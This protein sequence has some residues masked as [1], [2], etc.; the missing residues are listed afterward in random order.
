MTRVSV[1][2]GDITCLHEQ[3]LRPDAVVNAANEHLAAG[4]GVC[5]AI[6]AAAGHQE[7]TEACRSLGGCPTGSAVATPAFG[8]AAH[9]VHHIV[10]AVG[11]VWRAG[12]EAESDALLADT[13][14]AALAVA[15][16]AGAHRVAVPAISTGIY[17][18]PE[19][20][21]ASITARTVLEDDGPLDDVWLVAFD[22]HAATVLGDALAAERARHGPGPCQSCGAPQAR[23]WSSPDGPARLCPPCATLQGLGCP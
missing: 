2:V 9:G 15:G 20:R 16:Q 14:R 3:G 23:W 8:L 7:L 12:H 21:A 6:F 4:S 17:G 1:V 5:G 13:Y 19:E 11:P 10:H 18:F 22:T